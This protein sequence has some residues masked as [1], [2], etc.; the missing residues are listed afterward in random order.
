MEDLCEFK[1]SLVYRVKS[2]TVSAEK[3]SPKNRPLRYNFTGQWHEES[4]VRG[5]C[6]V[7]VAS[8]TYME[9]LFLEVSQP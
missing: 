8:D 4:Y 1:A 6:L 9:M 2:R 5:S 3:P 7:P